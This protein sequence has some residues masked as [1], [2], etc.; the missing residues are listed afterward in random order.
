MLIA[1]LLM[2]NTH[3]L[4]INHPIHAL[5]LVAVVDYAEAFLLPASHHH[6]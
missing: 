5:F 3:F 2:C 1:D 4:I 6:S